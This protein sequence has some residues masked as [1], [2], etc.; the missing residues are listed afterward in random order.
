V[1]V[2]KYKTKSGTR[3]RAEFEFQGVRVPKAGFEKKMEAQTWIA[4]ERIRMEE[5]SKKSGVSRELL[6][7]KVS[8]AYLDYCE[9]RLRPTTTAQKDFVLSNLALF[10]GGNPP[11]KDVTDA[12]I[13]DYLKTSR[14]RAVDRENDPNKTAN[15]DLR[16][17]NALFNWALHQKQFA[18]QIAG[19]PCRYVQAFPEE[20]AVR[21]VPPAEDIQK[22][23]LAATPWE[24][25]IITVLLHTGARIGEV[26]NLLWDDL[27]M[28]RKELRLW[29][30][31]RKGGARQYRTLTMGPTLESLFLRVWRERDK[32]SP[33]VFT[34]PETGTGWSKHS[35]PMKFFM[36]RI[37][38]RAGVRKIEFH[39]LRHYVARLARDSKK[40]TSFELQKFLGHQRLGTTEI[41]LRDLGSSTAGVSQI[42]EDLVQNPTPGSHIKALEK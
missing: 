37:C 39:S 15:R 8:S 14:K 28:E 36:S 4:T 26:R 21:Y 35:W 1:S 19:N 18:G 20:E 9:G 11:M 3:Y 13:T 5:E 27:S 2:T 42:L 24:M 31:K 17:I 10:M 7:G 29:T 12:K 6:W 23:L 16:E 34:N 38:K 33:Y 25:D 30:R 40:A 22:V 41:Y 32:K